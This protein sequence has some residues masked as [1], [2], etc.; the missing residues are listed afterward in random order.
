MLW[1]TAVLIAHHLDGRYADPKMGTPAGAVC[2]VDAGTGQIADPANMDQPGQRHLAHPRSSCR[3]QSRDSHGAGKRSR[4]CQGGS[5]D[6]RERVKC[7]TASVSRDTQRE[8]KPSDPVPAADAEP[9]DI[10]RAATA[11][12]PDTVQ[13]ASS[14]Q[15]DNRTNVLSLESLCHVDLAGRNDS[16]GIMANRAVVRFAART[17]CF[18]SVSSR[19]RAGIQGETVWM[20]DQVRMTFKGAARTFLYPA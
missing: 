4:P 6:R 9:V 11:M 20:P 1:Q 5:R 12:E 3:P 18:L 15:V 14:Q 16:A 2:P 13:P 7:E 8:R 19:P 10:D 17:L